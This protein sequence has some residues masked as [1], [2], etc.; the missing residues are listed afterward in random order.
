MSCCGQAAE[1]VNPISAAAAT[2]V[3]VR[4]NTV[5]PG[6]LFRGQTSR[7]A[8]RRQLAVGFKSHMPQHR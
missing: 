3:N 6:A 4:L 8:E 5:F 7:V 2:A 1:L